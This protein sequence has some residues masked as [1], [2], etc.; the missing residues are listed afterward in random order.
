MG[1]A[2]NGNDVAPTLEDEI[3]GMDFVDYQDENQ[4]ESVMSLV[5]HD[6]SEP[7]SSKTIFVLHKMVFM[8]WLI[9]ILWLPEQSLRIITFCIGFR[10]CE[11]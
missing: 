8:S 5:G 6:L 4:L 11:S 10:S 3:E 1:N 2:S 7:Y 9:S